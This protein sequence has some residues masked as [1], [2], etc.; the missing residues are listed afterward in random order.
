MNEMYCAEQIQIPPELGT[1]LKLLT[2][3]AIRDKPADVYKWA[4]NFFAAQCNRPAAFDAAGALTAAGRE[5]MPHSQPFNAATRG[6]GSKAGGAGG[7]GGAA[8]A[9][10]GAGRAGAGGASPAHPRGSPPS[11]SSVPQQAPDA[12]TGLSAEDD[13]IIDGLFDKYDPDRTN[14]IGIDMLPAL[15]L[16]LKAEL[17]LD[18]SHEQMEDFV[19]SMQP[20]ETGMIS[21]DEFRVSFF[22]G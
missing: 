20:D 5:T 14:L 6:A 2:K 19:N 7:G 3:A 9:T 18:F 11:S 16:E 8:A 13:A 10:P 1:V 12:A 22:Q 17:Q 4:A 15:I 21:L